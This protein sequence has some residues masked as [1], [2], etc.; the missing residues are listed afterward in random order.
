MCGEFNW[1]G[2]ACTGHAAARH[3]S[4]RRLRSLFLQGRRARVFTSPGGTARG[5]KIWTPSRERYGRRGIIGGFAHSLWFL[6]RLL[7][8]IFGGPMRHFFRFGVFGAGFSSTW[9]SV[10][11]VLVDAEC[12]SSMLPI[13]LFT[14]VR[15]GLPSHGGSAFSRS[16]SWL[17]LLTTAA[18]RGMRAARL[19][20]SGRRASSW[21]RRLVRPCNI[22]LTASHVSCSPR[23]SVASSPP[24]LGT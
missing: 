9:V 10:G 1:Y 11:G 5:D 3:N 16:S 22:L 21:L 17:S 8:R 6:C 4:V 23:D 18:E 15:L 7:W 20:A 24:S 12:D 19:S 13:F 2:H 14:Y